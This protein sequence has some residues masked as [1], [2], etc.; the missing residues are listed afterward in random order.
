MSQASE[1]YAN[2]SN[3]AAATYAKLNHAKEKLNAFY[4]KVGEPPVPPEHAAEAKQLVAE[5]NKL[6][7]EYGKADKAQNEA[8]KYLGEI[9]DAHI[10]GK[11]YTSPAEMGAALPPPGKKGKQGEGGGPKKGGK[12]FEV[13]PSF[14]LVDAKAIREIKES[15]LFWV[16]KHTANGSIL[17]GQISKQAMDIVNSGMDRGDAAKIFSDKMAAQFGYDPN[18]PTN[19]PTGGLE[20][21]NA[22]RGSS[23]S[24]FEMLGANAVTTARNTGH[25]R[26]FQQIGIT[27]YAIVNPEDERTC[28]SCRFMAGK[29]FET[30]SAVKR[31][32]SILDQE[33]PEKIKDLHPWDKKKEILSK[34][35]ASEKDGHVSKEDSK[36]LEAAG[37]SYPPYHGRCRCSVDIT[38]SAE[39]L[40][41]PE[42]AKPAS[43]VIPV[44]PPAP[45]VL[46]QAPVV[47]AP[48]SPPFVA[49]VVVTP[50][51]VVPQGLPATFP[52][53]E[54]QLRLTGEKLGGMHTKHVYED[55]SGNQWIFKPQEDFR[56][57]GDTMAH[58]I[59]KLLGM[60]T[61]DVYLVN[62][63]GRVGSIQSRFKDVQTEI[64]SLATTALTPA[65]VEAVQ[66]EH[67]FD[68]LISQH[69]THS[70]NIL[71]L[72][73]GE[74]RGIDKGQTFRFFGLDRFDLSYGKPGE[75]N[76]TGTLYHTIFNEYA[77]GKDIKVQ[78]LAALDPF[79]K[80]IES[81]PDAAFRKT[82]DA[83]ATAAWDAGQKNPSMK[84]ASWMGRFKSK[85]EFLDAVVARKQNIRET[86]TGFYADLEKQRNKALGIKA[87]RKPRKPKATPEVFPEKP[88]EKPPEG[89]FSK[90]TWKEHISDAIAGKWQGTHSFGR[91]DRR[92]EGPLDNR[93][94]ACR[95]EGRVRRAPRGGPQG[96][97][98]R[99][100]LGQARDEGRGPHRHGGHVPGPDATDSGADAD[101][102]GRG[103][104]RRQR[105]WRRARRGRSGGLGSRRVNPGREGQA[106]AVAEA[107]RRQARREGR[108]EGAREGWKEDVR[109]PSRRLE[110]FRRPPD[111]PD[112]GSRSDGLP[113]DVHRERLGPGLI[114]RSTQQRRPASQRKRPS[115]RQHPLRDPRREVARGD[116]GGGGQAAG[117]QGGRSGQATQRREGGLEDRRGREHG[118]AAT[119]EE[120]LLE[121]RAL[122]T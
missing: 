24:Y 73:N 36:K 33:D 60:E 88:A 12:F 68:W 98:H 25:I 122:G 3:T 108:R 65:Q 91:Y 81:I 106:P 116:R 69:D 121:R 110:G 111:E 112:Q 43:E 6:A 34:S 49:P 104:D 10:H 44:A 107:G 35:G 103:R 40:Y 45:P 47:L 62:I 18:A 59:Q 7:A 57:K 37:F 11:P 32:E 117:R 71:V 92:Q 19:N 23:M 75:P 27:E 89:A 100:P 16:G 46:V 85:D 109:R 9:E 78:P 66:K 76:G 42:P 119:R 74:L 120:E 17:S 72:K 58:D 56:A 113:R 28:P 101:G 38:E 93:Q 51:P 77:K 83:Y 55:P 50:P 87:P 48:P 63:G 1:A 102:A 86:V 21:P 26:S 115:A 94:G 97:G 8:A 64:K 99:H 13:K 90:K 4:D 14:D 22:W 52:W 118:H 53:K 80:K 15:Q 82:I 30:E 54:N 20:I 2:A 95:R 114:P 41:T 31:Q 96:H 5:A 39:V 67:V 79:L 105:G 84:A 70:E 29:H 61:N